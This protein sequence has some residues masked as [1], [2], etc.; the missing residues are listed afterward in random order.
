MSD[1]DYDVFISVLWKSELDFTYVKIPNS[2][3]VR[4]TLTSYNF[5]SIDKYTNKYTDILIMEFYE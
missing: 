4:Y 1:Y 5:I 3:L 2:P